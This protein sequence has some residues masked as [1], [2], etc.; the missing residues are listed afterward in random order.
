VGLRNVRVKRRKEER[1]RKSV[2]SEMAITSAFQA[3]I[4]SSSLSMRRKKERE[5]NRKMFS[6]ES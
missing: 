6:E 5:K 2:F 4:E 1:K 3:V